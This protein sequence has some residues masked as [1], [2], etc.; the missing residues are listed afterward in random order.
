MIITIG[1]K[2]ADI[3]EVIATTSRV[4]ITTKVIEIGETTDLIIEETTAPII[5]EEKGTDEDVPIGD[6]T[7]AEMSVIG[8]T[9][10]GVEM[11][12]TDKMITAGTITDTA[13]T[14][15]NQQITK[16]PKTMRVI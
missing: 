6:L 9:P 12:G 11:I 5:V 7:M 1:D 4:E 14:E 13:R 10:R 16:N 8:Q 15:T 3:K 2:Q